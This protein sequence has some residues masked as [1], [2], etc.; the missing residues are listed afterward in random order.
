[1]L[2]EVL[3]SSL[4]VSGHF[5]E[6]FEVK[7]KMLFSFV[8]Y[9]RRGWGRK[10]TSPLPEEV[11]KPMIYYHLSVWENK[12]SNCIFFVLFFAPFPATPFSGRDSSSEH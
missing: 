8:M 5:L 3:R 2:R 12:M 11:R 1:M 6:P 4:N 9:G 7:P 10:V